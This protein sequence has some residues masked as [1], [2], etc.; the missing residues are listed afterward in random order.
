MAYLGG[1]RAVLY[2]GQETGNQILQVTRT[3]P[4]EIAL[5]DLDSGTWTR[6]AVAGVVPPRRRELSMVTASLGSAVVFGGR[7]DAGNFLDDLWVRRV[8]EQRA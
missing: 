1:N 4:E 3:P 6:V 8:R 5:L 2:G 7:D